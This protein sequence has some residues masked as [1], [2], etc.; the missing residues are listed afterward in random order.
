MNLNKFNLKMP[1]CL[2]QCVFEAFFDHFLHT[3]VKQKPDSLH[4]NKNFPKLNSGFKKF[5]IG[6]KT[7]RR[8]SENSS[9]SQNF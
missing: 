2:T 4:G 1:C 3:M 8:F 6:R 9:G 5:K 7:E